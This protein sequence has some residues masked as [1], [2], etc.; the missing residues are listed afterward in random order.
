MGHVQHF[1]IVG[2]VVNARFECLFLMSHSFDGL[3]DADPIGAPCRFWRVVEDL[4]SFNWEAI[5]SRIFFQNVTLT[6]IA[7]EFIRFDLAIANDVQ[8]LTSNVGWRGGE[9]GGW[10]QEH[11]SIFRQKVGLFLH[12]LGY[13]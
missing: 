8:R 11:G 5:A 4:V 7:D 3:F 6:I 13:N 10:I 9:I 12:P 2:H 1:E